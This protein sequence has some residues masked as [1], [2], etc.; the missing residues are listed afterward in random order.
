M[1]SGMESWLGDKE[2]ELGKQD[3]CVTFIVF[4]DVEKENKQAK[5]NS[6]GIIIFEKNSLKKFVPD[7]LVWGR[8]MA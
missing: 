4:L 2:S 1:F 5:R 7:K 3:Y 8:I 6:G